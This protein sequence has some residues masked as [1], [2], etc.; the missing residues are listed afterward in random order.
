LLYSKSGAFVQASKSLFANKLKLGATLRADKN[1]YFSVKWN[2]RFTMVYSPTDDHNF[3]FSYQTGYRFPSIFEAFSNV[4][5]GG[6]KRVGGLPVMSN[7]IFENGWLRAS[8]DAFQAAINTDVNKNGLTKNQAIV[9]N[10]NLLVKNDYTYIQPEQIQSLEFGYRS[11]FLNDDLQLDVDFYYNKYSQFIAQVEMNIPKTSKPDSIPFYLA[12]KTKQDRYRLWT[13]SKTVAYN[14]GS[15]LGVKYRFYKNF[16]AMGNV[17]LSRFD[18]KSSNDGFEDGFNTPQWITNISVGN[19]NLIKKLG[20]MLTYHW[21][22]SYYWQ[23][24][25][26]NGDVP[27]FYTI[28]AQ[29]SYQWDKIKL[30]VGGTNILDKYYQSYLGGP[31]VGGFYYTTVSLNL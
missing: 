1:D 30:K 31:S 9:K 25:L 6:V 23:S 20:F 2:P 5:S 10:Q 27:S 12:D 3:R 11:L 17:T 21:Q 8:I 22:S 4:N 14:Y 24:F 15:S 16:K 19:D 7:G 26:V 28:D 29:V 13:N 18:H